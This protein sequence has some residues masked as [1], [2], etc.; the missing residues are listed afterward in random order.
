MGNNTTTIHNLEIVR[1]DKDKNMV[2]VKGSVP[3]HK[4]T[5]IIVKK[6]KQ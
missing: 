3:G 5:N 2:M 4:N 6:I 1:V